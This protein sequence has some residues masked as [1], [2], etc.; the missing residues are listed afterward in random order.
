M[1]A[2]AEQP[3]AGGVG[4]WYRGCRSCALACG[5]SSPCR[6]PDC[7][8]RRQESEGTGSGVHSF[9]F[10]RVA[11]RAFVA[12]QAVQPSTVDLLLLLL[13]LLLLPASRGSAR[14]GWSEDH[15]PSGCNACR[16]HGFVWH[17]GVKSRVLLPSFVRWQSCQMCLLCLLCL[18]V[19][20]SSP[21]V[22]LA[23]LKLGVHFEWPHLASQ[24]QRTGHRFYALT[25]SV[26]LAERL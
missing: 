10:L 13:L 1:P 25:G 12:L 11:W 9:D 14:S 6:P 7:S 24:P 19:S 17:W 18:F 3:V 8:Q 4:A 21:S 22:P 5:G 20:F 26:V 23:R 16:T 15:R 2:K